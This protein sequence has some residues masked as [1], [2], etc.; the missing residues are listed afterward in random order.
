MPFKHYV[1]G[2]PFA[3]SD[4]SGLENAQADLFAGK[5]W[6]VS[7]DEP[8]VRAM[9]ET[10]G[11]RQIVVDPKEHDEA[12]AFTSHLPQVISTAL[13][14]LIEQKRIDPMFVGGGIRTLLRL[15]GSSYEVW[16]S[17]L[18]A[19][20]RNIGEAERELLRVMNSM[21]GADFDRARRFMAKFAGPPER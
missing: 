12:M 2:H 7:R 17:V 10:T 3:G 8:A 18:D 14:S 4:K 13:A 6:F 11:A 19:N 16:G 5:P 21:T 1:A 9:I 15:A 20:A